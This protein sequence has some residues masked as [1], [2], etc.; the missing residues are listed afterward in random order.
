MRIL[1]YVV[2]WSG[3]VHDNNVW[4]TTDQ[5]LHYNEFFSHLHYI[6]TDSAVTSI[7][8]I[9]AF[10]RLYRIHLLLEDQQLFNNLLAKA[11]I[12]T[13]HTAVTV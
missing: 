12:K 11:K 5:Y 10:K 4:S 13:E 7:Y 9:L 6:I 1:E 3:S 2:G 8:L